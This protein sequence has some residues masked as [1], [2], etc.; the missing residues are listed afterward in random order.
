M[1]L[2]F[3]FYQIQLPGVGLLSVA[4]EKSGNH[5]NQICPLQKS[6]LLIQARTPETHTHSLSLS[7]WIQPQLLSY[8][9]TKVRSFGGYL[10]EKDNI[11]DEI[12][13]RQSDSNHFADMFI[14]ILEQWLDQPEARDRSS[15]KP[16]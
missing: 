13:Q 3:F 11:D 1:C 5:N 7:L 10:V 9:A 16:A 12:G 4:L 15:D 14:L 2:R 8:L 6:S